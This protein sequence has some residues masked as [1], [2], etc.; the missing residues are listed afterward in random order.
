MDDDTARRM[1]DAEADRLSTARGALVRERAEL[2]G[3]RSMDPITDP[4]LVEREID[5]SLLHELD[6][7]L[8][9]IAEAHRRLDAGTFGTCETCGGPIGDDRLAVVPAARRCVDHQ[10]AAEVRVVERGERGDEGGG[11]A[12]V[13]ARQHL[14]LVP[15]DDDGSSEADPT[16]AAGGPEEHA[17]HVTRP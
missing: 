2:Q 5:D 1:L 9:A 14:D 4:G 10:M 13:E 7:E 16:D 6:A 11:T 8:A 12:P 15:D 17:I 3:E